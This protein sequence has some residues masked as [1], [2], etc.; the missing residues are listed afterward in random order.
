M[1]DQEESEA[2]GDSLY[3]PPLTHSWVGMPVGGLQYICLCLTGVSEWGE[4]QTETVERALSVLDLPVPVV[5]PVPLPQARARSHVGLMFHSWNKNDVLAGYREW[6]L[7]EIG[8]RREL[9]GKTWKQEG[10]TCGSGPEGKGG[11][12]DIV[13]WEQPKI[14]EC[15]VGALLGGT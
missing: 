13:L 7:V 9:L 1:E 8:E 2:E 6:E 4:S 3:S 15:W 11:V 5:A 12:Q 14:E 10:T